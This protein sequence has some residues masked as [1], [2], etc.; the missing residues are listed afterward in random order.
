MP[1]I[2]YFNLFQVKISVKYGCDTG[3]SLTVGGGWVG[4]GA[5]RFPF[6][7]ENSFFSFTVPYLMCPALS[8]LFASYT[9]LSH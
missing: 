1:V 5:G 6:Y 3:I 8:F 7:I 9:I 2:I 4:D